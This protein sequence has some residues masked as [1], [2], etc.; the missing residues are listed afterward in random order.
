MVVDIEGTETIWTEID[1]AF[2]DSLQ[3]II[4]ELHPQYSGP[5]LAAQA[6]QAVIE[7]GF[8]LCGYQNHVLAFS[9]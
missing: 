6:A 2:P 1:A 5:E 4:T 9:R 3:L 7:Q 8:R